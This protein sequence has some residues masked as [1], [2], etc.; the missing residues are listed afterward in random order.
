MGT[1]EDPPIVWDID[2]FSDPTVAGTLAAEAHA[3]GKYHVHTTPWNVTIA[4]TV[5]EGI[6]YCTSSVSLAL[7]SVGTT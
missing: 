3:R 4:D 7:A 1:V 2:E 5:P 6:H